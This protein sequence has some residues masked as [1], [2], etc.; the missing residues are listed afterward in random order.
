MSQE[1]FRDLHLVR[2]EVVYIVPKE[3]TVF[4]NDRAS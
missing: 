2:D 3:I 1:R 4:E